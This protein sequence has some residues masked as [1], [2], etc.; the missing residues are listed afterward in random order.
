MPCCL[1]N[2]AESSFGFKMRSN[3]LAAG[4]SNSY[5]NLE[6]LTFLVDG[7]FAIMITLLVLELRPPEESISP[8]VDGL[9]GMW[10]RLFIYFIAFFSL[11]NHWA[12]HQR[13]FRHITE[14]DSVVL[15]LT[16]LGLLFITLIPATTALVGRFPHEKIAVACFS[17]NSFLQ[18]LISWIFWVY[19]VRNQKKFAV[20]SDPRLLTITAQVWLVISAGWLLSIPL[21][22]INVNAAYVTWVAWPNLVAIWG[23]YKRRSLDTTISHEGQKKQK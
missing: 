23:N 16:L 19:V 14:A 2:K 4:E 13:M 21:G 6:R 8:L 22:F 11:A 18:A 10:P 5:V 20:H 1:A 12:V 17:A 3:S 15:W 7:V 9:L